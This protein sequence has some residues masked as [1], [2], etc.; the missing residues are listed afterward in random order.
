MD[1]M[2]QL[3]RAA[4]LILPFCVY[5]VTNPDDLSAVS[6]SPTI[7]YHIVYGRAITN[8]AKNIPYSMCIHDEA[9]KTEAA[10]RE[11]GGILVMAVST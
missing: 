10:V 9:K 1:T 11:N 6:N 7:R 4:Y 5:I 8:S 2:K 3:S